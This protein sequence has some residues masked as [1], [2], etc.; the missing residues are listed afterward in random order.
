MF[1]LCTAL[2]AYFAL[3]LKT[4]AVMSPN[5][6]MNKQNICNTKIEKDAQTRES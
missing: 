6:L 4:F 3:Q 5:M 1:G 2:E